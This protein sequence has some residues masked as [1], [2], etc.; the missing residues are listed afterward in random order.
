MANIYSYAV[1]DWECVNTTLLSV[2]DDKFTGSFSFNGV[3]AYAKTTILGSITG[4]LS[5]ELY[6]H[7][8]ISPK[9][10]NLTQGLR[11]RIDIY[12]KPDIDNDYW[13]IESYFVYLKGDDSGEITQKLITL[14]GYYGFFDHIDIRIEAMSDVTMNNS[15]VL[16][17]VF[18]INDTG[19]IPDL[20]E[21]RGKVTDNEVRLNNQEFIIT[22]IISTV[23]AEG[24]RLDITEE[25][26]TTLE[27]GQLTFSETFAQGGVNL[28]NNPT[29]G[30]R[31]APDKTGWNSGFT[32]GVFISRFEGATVG[33]VITAIGDLTITQVLEYNW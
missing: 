26:V 31:Y 28:F 12:S 19:Y 7:G 13:D 4:P 9:Q 2:E 29:Y 30:G 24:E 18:S 15:S 11:C 6:L 20:P 14:G 16:L 23:N 22:E 10:G 25:R 1:A 21:I 3:G 17:T 27:A 33:E 32:V 8:Y 5:S